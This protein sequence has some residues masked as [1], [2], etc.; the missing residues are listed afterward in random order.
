[1][2]GRARKA[3]AWECAQGKRDA[4]GECGL[5]QWHMGIGG[6]K[7]SEGWD[8]GTQAQEGIRRVRA[9][10]L[11]HLQGSTQAKG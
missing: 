10:T 1:M 7:E 6:H 3:S 5:G 4:Q 11:K 9:G 2:E 8:N